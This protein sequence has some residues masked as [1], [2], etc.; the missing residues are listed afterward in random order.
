[1]S[2]PKPVFVT[3]ENSLPLGKCVFKVTRVMFQNKDKK[4]FYHV[5]GE[6][7]GKRYQLI[8]NTFDLGRSKLRN[9]SEFEENSLIEVSGKWDVVNRVAGASLSKNVS[10]SL[11]NFKAPEVE[12]VDDDEDDLVVPEASI[13]KNSNDDVLL[14]QALDNEMK[15]A[16][17]KARVKLGEFGDVLEYY[18][19]RKRGISDELDDNAVP[20]VDKRPNQKKTRVDVKTED[21]KEEELDRKAMEDLEK[22]MLKAARAREP[23]GSEAS[24]MV[25]D[26]ESEEDPEEEEFDEDDPKGKRVKKEPVGQ[27]L[28][29]SFN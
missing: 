4:G 19:N 8:W 18:E 15:L 25:V 23:G 3:F 9:L 28:G 7:E 27:F 2:A 29:Q 24:A 26:G 21:M 13:Y 11:R 17:M 6:L 1:M 20:D 5:E 16:K 14:M 12:Q 10:V 22:L